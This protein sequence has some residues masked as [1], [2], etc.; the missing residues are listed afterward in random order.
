MEGDRSSDAVWVECAVVAAHSTGTGRA[1]IND[2]A[3]QV[4]MKVNCGH[5]DLVA[6]ADADGLQCQAQRV[7][8][9]ADAHT[10]CGAA[11][12]REV[13]FKPLHLFAKDELTALQH[14]RTRC[15]KGGAVTSVRPGHVICGDVD[16]RPS[17]RRAACLNSSYS[18]I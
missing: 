4:A 15:L 12:A 18:R 14:G 13:L 17:R 8:A 6:G 7:Q 9:V 1:P 5:E 16:Q 10:V 2:T 3:L 11:I